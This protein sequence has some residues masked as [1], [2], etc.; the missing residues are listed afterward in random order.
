MHYSLK[1]RKL[2]V[3]TKIVDYEISDTKSYEGVWHVEGMSHEEI[4]ATCVY[5]LDR[6]EDLEGGN[7]LFK[8]AYHT[9][10][11][12]FIAGH[13]GQMRPSFINN[14][15]YD[16]LFPLGRVETLKK[17]MIVF[18]NSH[19]HKVTRLSRKSVTSLSDGKKNAATLTENVK[20]VGRR[21]IIVFFLVNPMKQIIS[22]SEVPPQQIEA[23]GSMRLEEALQHRLELMKERKY[24][25]QDFNVREINLCE[26]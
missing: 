25:K 26:H 10:E 1:E 9:N 20:D 2:Q 5:V 19:I 6:D 15:I 7:I 18:P 8:R 17:R 16:G 24:V 14:L 23:G 12:G 11:V 21:R 3:I 22:T 13:T 4:V